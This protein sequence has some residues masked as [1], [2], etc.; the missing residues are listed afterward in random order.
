[1]KSLRM[2]GFG[3]A[4]ILAMTGSVL[5]SQSTA[6]ERAE[7]RQLNLEQAQQS[8]T[9]ALNAKDAASSLPANAPPAA[10]PT[11][12]VEA[13]DISSDTI[14]PVTVT[15]RVSISASGP[16][17]ALAPMAL[18]SFTNPPDKVATARV[19]DSKGITI[20]AVQ[21]VDIDGGKPSRVEVALLGSNQIISL[22]ARSVSYDET[23]NVLM[24]AGDGQAV[25]AA[26]R[27]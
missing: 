1:M 8:G 4:A 13:S 5:A 20:G 18:N 3:G 6:Q 23:N 10:A 25:A 9:Q 21:K 17:P 14:A 11:M 26:P 19:V 7:T 24:A 12:P 27:G 16:E 22:D 15:P 2:I